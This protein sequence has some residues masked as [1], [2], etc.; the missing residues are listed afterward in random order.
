MSLISRIYAKIK[1]SRIKSVLQYRSID[2]VLSNNNSDFENYVSQMYPAELEIKTRRGN[3]SVSYLNLLLLIGRDVKLR[4]S[5]YDKRDDFNCHIKNC[6]FLSINIPYSPAYGVF[7][8]SIRYARACS[9][10]HVLF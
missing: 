10:M 4:T 6:P 8:Q 5:L 2:D 7:S 1:S 3:T 9:P